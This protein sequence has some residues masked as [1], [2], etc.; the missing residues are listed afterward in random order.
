MSANLC[1]RIGILR[2]VTA[3]H[4]HFTISSKSSDCLPYLV[5]SMLLNK[6][7]ALFSAWDS[8]VRLPFSPN[9]FYGCNWMTINTT[10]KR[11]KCTFMCM[12]LKIRLGSLYS[13]FLFIF[14]RLTLYRRQFRFTSQ[15]FD[16]RNVTKHRYL[17]ADS[18]PLTGNTWKINSMNV[19]KRTHIAFGLQFYALQRTATSAAAQFKH[20]LMETPHGIWTFNAWN[21]V[22]VALL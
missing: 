18:S 6:L 17:S 21:E 16:C 5:A 4:N 20:M 8:L 7:F 1:H 19:C 15:D 22:V 3:I 13:R 12:T 10:A 14:L 2:G 9:N 11:M